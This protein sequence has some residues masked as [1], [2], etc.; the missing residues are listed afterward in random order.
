MFEMY[1]E[2]KKGSQLHFGAGYPYTIQ[3]FSGLNPP[4]A[5]INTNTT[6][7][8]DGGK[9]NSSKL[10]MRSMNIAFAIESPAEENRLAVYQV[11]QCKQP[12]RLYFKSEMLDLFID[13]YVE[14]LDF[15]YFAMKNVATVSILCPST[16]FKGAQEIINELSSLIPLF[17][18]PTDGPIVFGSIVPQIS[19]EVE[20]DG[21]VETGLTIVMYAKDSIKNPKIFNYETNEF[22]GLNFTMQTGDEITITTGQGDKKITL[23]RGG[24]ETNIFNYL[25]KNS[26]WL[27]LNPGGSVFVYEVEEGNVIN[28]DIV[29][30]HY[31]LYE[32]V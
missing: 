3:E 29:I 22:L 20:N 23:L 2:N 5:V 10:Q 28:L 8:L 6:A 7:L 24:V 9:F 25:D 32:G 30:K 4:H 1:F 11:L 13:G 21:N 16:Y 12:I 15:T 14:D 17:H 18:F 26:T 31:D 27:Q 19:V